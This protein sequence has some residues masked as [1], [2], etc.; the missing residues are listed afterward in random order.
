MKKKTATGK[1]NKKTDE[2][3]KF[4]TKRMEQNLSAGRSFKTSFIDAVFA[5]CEKEESQFF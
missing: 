3:T 5:W 4:I 2:D 1:K